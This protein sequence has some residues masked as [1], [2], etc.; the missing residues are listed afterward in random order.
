MYIREI[1][2]KVSGSNLP[3]LM[4]D[5]NQIVVEVFQYM[6]H[7]IVNNN[8]K[9]TVKSYCYRLK[10]FYDWL[11]YAGLTYLTAIEGKSEKNKGLIEN[12]TDFKLWLKYGEMNNKVTPIGGY[13]QIRETSTINQIMDTVLSF[14]DYLAIQ[15]K[16]EELNVYKT[17][18]SN[19]QFGGFL[20][21]MVIKHEK[22]HKTSLF[23][24]KAVSKG[25][26]YVT[27][28][29]YEQSYQAATN[30]RD[31]IIIS[32]LFETGLRVS[33]TIGLH[34]EDFKEIMDGKI[35]IRNHNDKDNKDAALKYDSTGTVFVTPR[36]QQ[37]II[38]YINDVLSVTDT[39]YFLINLYGE[40]KNQPMR[41]R[42]IER[43]VKNIGKKIGRPDIHPHAYR[44]GL[45]VDMLSNGCNMV[46]IKDTL[47]HKNIETTSNI[48]AE[49]NITAKRQLMDEYHHKVE[50]DF[51]PDGIDIDSFLN[52]LLEDEKEETEND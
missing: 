45:A 25:L 15:D 41:T 26:K 18:R 9:N 44:H 36:M 19:S 34:I 32:L 23:K 51:M 2:T 31:K 37:D 8:S 39:N 50:T 47:R 11:S 30:L 43:M 38:K 21:E 14:Y 1:T 16:M 35:L 28:E 46:Q 12:F 4:N 27:R 40:T 22:N 13:E 3:V 7:L 6:K 10:L 42:N 48:Y 33:E 49:Y 17:T 29:E 20:N 52:M 24:E 5:N